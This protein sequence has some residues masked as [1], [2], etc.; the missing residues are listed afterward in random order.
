M[1]GRRNRPS[2]FWGILL[3]CCQEVG[4]RA[5]VDRLLSS[6]VEAIF[7][8]LRGHSIFLRDVQH[9]L[10]QPQSL[11]ASRLW[12]VLHSGH[13]SLRAGGSSYR[14]SPLAFPLSPSTLLPRS[15][16]ASC[17]WQVRLSYDLYL[18]PP[19]LFILP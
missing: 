5:G 2:N 3:C 10:D 8:F 15:S 13:G 19:K 18:W 1:H 4:A 7:S 9:L 6:P 14:P 11:T 17:A 12:T 16:T